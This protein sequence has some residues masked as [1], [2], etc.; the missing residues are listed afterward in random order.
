[1]SLVEGGHEHP[2]NVWRHQPRVAGTSALRTSRAIRQTPPDSLRNTMR[3][4]RRIGLTN[5]CSALTISASSTAPFPSSHS[6]RG[7]PPVKRHGPHVRG[8]GRPRRKS[9][10]RTVTGKT[11]DQQRPHARIVLLAGEARQRQV[12]RGRDHTCR[13]VVSAAAI[14]QPARCP[15]PSGGWEPEH[16]GQAPL[17]FIGVSPPHWCFRS[18]RRSSAFSSRRCWTWVSSMTGQYARPAGG[19]H[20]P[21]NQAAAG[22]S[23][24]MSPSPTRADRRSRD[25][26]CGR[27]SHDATSNHP[28]RPAR[29]ASRTAA[30]A[31]NLVSRRGCDA[32]RGPPTGP[33]SAAR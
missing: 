4:S 2:G 15:L 12:H 28:T 16:S 7:S 8:C 18:R 14:A 21:V 27:P 6:S 33:G 10:G 24:P 29:R 13:A 25:S 19:S 9:A 23:T 22:P 3:N 11:T 1:M 26:A 20:G 30:W 32:Q 17:D 31:A 5:D